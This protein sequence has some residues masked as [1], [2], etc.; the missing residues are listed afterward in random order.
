MTDYVLFLDSDDGYDGDETALSTSD[1][2]HPNKLL[3]MTH[4]VINDLSDSIKYTSYPVIRY[5]PIAV[6]IET[7][8]PGRTKKEA[9]VQLRV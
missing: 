3:E 8:T 7:K 5:R 1:T 9:R 4:A 2:H 6:S